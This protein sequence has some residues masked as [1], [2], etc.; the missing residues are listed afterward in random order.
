VKADQVL[1]TVHPH[2]AAASENTRE[3][4]GADTGRETLNGEGA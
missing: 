1:A 3:D 4:T 2:T